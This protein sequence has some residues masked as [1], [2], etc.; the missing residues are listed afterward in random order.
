RTA[1]HR[2]AT[3]DGRSG[4]AG[5][6]D[7]RRADGGGDLRAD[8]GRVDRLHDRHRTGAALEAVYRAHPRRPPDDA[9]REGDP[10]R[11]QG[12]RRD[13]R[14]VQERIGSGSG[15]GISGATLSTVRTCAA[16]RECS[17]SYKLL[18]AA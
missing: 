11:L 14:L 2:P 4:P 9:A 16:W 13:R 1:L 6:D 3:L 12:E 10:L 8:A 18:P 5:D 17:E 15:G 7:V